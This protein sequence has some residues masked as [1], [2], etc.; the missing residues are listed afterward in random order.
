MTSMPESKSYA[1]PTPT[2]TSGDHR[3]IVATSF[4]SSR[5]QRRRL[6]QKK[7]AASGERCLNL[8]QALK[9]AHLATALA[10]QRRNTRHRPDFANSRMLPSAPSMRKPST[11]ANSACCAGLR[12]LYEVHRTVLRAVPR[13]QR[14]WPRAASQLREKPRTNSNDAHPPPT[15]RA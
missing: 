10:E 5:K 3:T 9:P 6:L 14:C 11:R 8:R 7:S 13:A 4:T 2:A 15:A 12:R 1:Q